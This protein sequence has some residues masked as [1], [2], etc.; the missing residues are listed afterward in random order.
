MAGQP[1]RQ[2][3]SPPA[4][5]SST[6]SYFQLDWFSQNWDFTL[7]SWQEA[8]LLTEQLSQITWR[9]VLASRGKEQPVEITVLIRSISFVVK[10]R[11]KYFLIFIS[12]CLWE[13]EIYLYAAIANRTGTNS[14]LYSCFGIVCDY[15]SCLNPTLWVI[16]QWKVFYILFDQICRDDWTP[17]WG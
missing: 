11:Q 4:S 2:E 16:S 7:R 3:Q 5:Q 10:K 15:W 1:P 9:I 13:S 14:F 12:I 8:L 17:G 6:E